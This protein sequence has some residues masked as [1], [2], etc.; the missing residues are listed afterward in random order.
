[1]AVAA[2]PDRHGEPRDRRRVAPGADAGDPLRAPVGRGRAFPQ[3]GQ[4]HRARPPRFSLARR[5][6]RVAPTA[7][8]AHRRG[9]RR[10]DPEPARCRRSPFLYARS[11]LVVG[12]PA[13][14]RPG[15]KSP[16]F[17]GSPSDRRSR[18]PAPAVC[19]RSRGRRR[20]RLDALLRRVEKKPTLVLSDRRCL[21]SSFCR[22]FFELCDGKCLE[23]PDSALEFARLAVELARRVDV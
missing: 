7:P 13:S 9:P 4:H 2:D 6:R 20:R 11:S 5:P 8:E 12:A 15:T 21:K 1:M 14:S 18:G 3:R 19:R 10:A 22:R 16:K 17:W 23:E